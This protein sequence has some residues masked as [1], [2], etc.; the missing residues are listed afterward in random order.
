M[1][2][3]DLSNKQAATQRSAQ[4]Q[5]MNILSSANRSNS[6]NTTSKDQLKSHERSALSN[7]QMALN[8]QNSQ[9][10]ASS[11]FPCSGVEACRLFKAYLSEYEQE[12]I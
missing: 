3:I 9:P 1:K 5:S 11:I 10:K 8:T 12:E 7:N 4:K 6:S 2:P